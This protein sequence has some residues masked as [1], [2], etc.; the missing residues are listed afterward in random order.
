MKPIC[1]EMEIGLGGG[2]LSHILPFNAN[3]LYTTFRIIRFFPYLPHNANVFYT[4]FRIN[5]IILAQTQRGLQGW[6][7]TDCNAGLAAPFHAV[8]NDSRGSGH[9]W[10]ECWRAVES[11]TKLQCCTDKRLLFVAL[12]VVFLSQ[13]RR[14]ISS[15][16]G[17]AEGTN[18]W[19]AFAGPQ[20][21][22]TTTTHS[23]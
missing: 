16:W 21:T 17:M 5:S 23:N 9:M 8:N 7:Q 13:S 1:F 15:L 22:M 14:K 19:I 12:L 18:Q 2:V 20:P 11:I 4:T 6:L 3:V 10:T